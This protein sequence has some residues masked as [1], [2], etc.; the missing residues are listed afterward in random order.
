M[1]H[2]WPTRQDVSKRAKIAPTPFHRGYEDYNRLRRKRQS[3][4]RLLQKILWRLSRSMH[5]WS[6]KFP[7]L[8]SDPCDLSF[9]SRRA[10]SS[11]LPIKTLPP[12]LR[13][14]SSPLPCDISSLNKCHV[15]GPTIPHMLL[16]KWDQQVAHAN[17]QPLV[18][19]YVCALR[20]PINLL[21]TGQ[22]Q[23]ESAI[24]SRTWQIVAS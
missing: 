16:F 10:I 13:I 3:H 23:K 9:S 6:I 19:I 7:L 21:S 20:L 1:H 14:S 15:F 2:P 18:H 22:K 17:L 4:V 11:R 5:F 24:F 12:S 8:F